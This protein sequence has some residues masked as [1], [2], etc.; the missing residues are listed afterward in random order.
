MLRKANY[1]TWSVG[2]LALGFFACSLLSLAVSLSW[3]QEEKPKA[4]K[5][6]ESKAEA[7]SK[8][9]AAKVELEF[10]PKIPGGKEMVTDSSADFLKP[11]KDLPE[12][13]TVAKK[14][15]TIDFALFPGQDY[16]GRPWSNWGESVV[17][18][19]KY[20][21]AIGDHLA[22]QGNAYVFEYDPNTKKI[23]KIMD[24]KKL[25]NMPEGHYAPGKI[26]SRLGVGKDGWLYCTTHRGSTSITTDQYHYKGDWIVRT[27]PATAEMQVVQAAP[28]EKHCLPCA[29]V[30]PDRLI[31]YGGSAPGS[32]TDTRGIQFWAYDLA[33]RKMIYSGPDGPARAM[34]VSKSTGK[35][36][37]VP[38]KGESG[39]MRFDPATG[40]APEA[41]PGEISIR[42]ATDET[43]SGKVYV[44]GQRTGGC[45]LYE[46]DVKT[47]K[48][49][50]LGPAAVGSEQYVACLS[51]DA[52]GKYVYYSPGAHGGGHRDGSPLVQYNTQTGK[53]KVIAF[54][55]P[56]YKDK[57][58][59]DVQGTYA[60][61]V[62]PDGSRV[63]ICWNAGRGVKSWD[64]CALTSIAIPESERE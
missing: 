18:D 52:T 38:G 40:K 28:V 26:H 42:C 39:F 55:S 2:S 6:E 64:C 8:A 7:R 32:K 54:L 17:H 35:V 4:K 16:P 37:Y 50:N 11:V 27:N 46:F 30:D 9:K 15:P 44:A 20:Y 10:P 5:K 29:H 47:E 25:L 14:P 36:Y 21:C 1:F 61:S 12:G 59:I 33:N 43:P 3:S 41:I 49:R 48:I 60:V 23:R 63:F 34:I 45:D 57:Y 56:F 62:T 19:G 13:V 22:P 53:R 51:A 31:I 24:L 58:G